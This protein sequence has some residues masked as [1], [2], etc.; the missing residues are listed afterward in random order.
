MIDEKSNN[1]RSIKL[2]F[3]HNDKGRLFLRSSNPNFKGDT[4]IHKE[5]ITALYTIKGKI[6]RNLI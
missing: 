3:E 6:T 4:V 1:L 5:S 2:I